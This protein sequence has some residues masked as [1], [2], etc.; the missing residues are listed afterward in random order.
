MRLTTRPAGNKIART[1]DAS[2]SLQLTCGFDLNMSEEVR[3][4]HTSAIFFGLEDLSFQST[5]HR[6]G[7]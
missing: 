5:I 6:D 2:C 1:F 3:T 7:A 4:S